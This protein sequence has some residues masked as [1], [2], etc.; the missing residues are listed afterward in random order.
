VSHSGPPGC[1]VSCGDF[2][3]ISYSYTSEKHIVPAAIEPWSIDTVLC[4]P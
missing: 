2:G 4:L 3:A 1:W